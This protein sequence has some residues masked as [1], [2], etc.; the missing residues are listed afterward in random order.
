[1]KSIHHALLLNFQEG[2]ICHRGRGRHP[3]RLTSK[4]P[5]SEQIFRIQDAYRGF[6]SSFGQDSKFNFA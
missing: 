2:A 3:K 5:V 4:A 1:M 6:L